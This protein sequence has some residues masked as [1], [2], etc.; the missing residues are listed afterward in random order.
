LSFRGYLCSA[1]RVWARF[2]VFHAHMAPLALQVNRSARACPL[3]HSFR[4]R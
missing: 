4:M 3:F 1:A 2:A